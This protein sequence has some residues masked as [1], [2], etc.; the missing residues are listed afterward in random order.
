MQAK[1][2]TIEA[3]ARQ[4]DFIEATADEVLFG[5]A[6]G[7]GKSW[8][9][10]I[11]ALIYALKYP[12]SKQL[13]LRR[14]YPELEKSIIRQHLEI[15]PDKTIYKYN[16]SKHTGTFSNGSVIDFGYCAAEKDVYQYQG[17]EY[18][19]IRFDE[20]THFTEFMYMYLLSRLRGANDY[21]KQ[22]KST[23]NPG[24]V[25]HVWV[26]KR[27][28]EIAP[29][30]TEYIA[31]FGTRI[32]LPSK[33]QDNPALQAK[34]PDYIK[35]LEQLPEKERK[36][37]LFGD[38][39]IFEGQYF[40]EWDKDIH[41][42]EPFT[43]PEW[44]KRYV[45][46][47]YGLDMFACYFIAIDNNNRAYVYKEI[48]TGIDNEKEG[49]A[50]VL[51]R[52]AAELIKQASNGEKIESFYAPPDL[53]NSQKETGKSIAELFSESG[54][55]LQRASNNRVQGWYNL[56]EWLQV[57]TDEQGN[58]VAGLRI[59]NNC[60]NLIRTLPSLQHDSKNPNDTANQPHELTHAPDAIRYFVAG[61]PTPAQMPVKDGNYLPP[62][63]RTQ[64][65]EEGY[66]W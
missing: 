53:W 32:F 21:P 1:R 33:V 63:L 11:D 66:L 4:F 45:T 17:A 28:I 42:L 56:K 46:L 18:D 12:G 22:I 13:I 24:N 23:A 47:D 61:R 19:T 39:D 62:E 38:W 15:Y 50:P 54:I 9:Q 30:E 16:S 25:G 8:G 36:A 7:G 59:F 51:P 2:L 10:I 34:D 40:N 27:F 49:G 29:T 26:K 41:E 64:E 44:W 65:K 31:E 3:T 57:G 43:M 5:G 55:Y 20:L 14:T 52:E 60:R 58:K 6:A 37:L 48:Y 35:R